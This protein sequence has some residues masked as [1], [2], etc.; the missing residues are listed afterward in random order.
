M[1]LNIH[2]DTKFIFSFGNMSVGVD[3]ILIKSWVIVVKGVLSDDVPFG[4]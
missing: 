3:H 2:G 4:L 1:E